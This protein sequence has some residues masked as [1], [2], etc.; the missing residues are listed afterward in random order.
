M[1][2][3]KE[4]EVFRMLHLKSAKRG[5][6][7]LP[8]LCPAVRSVLPF[9]VDRKPMFILLTADII[10]RQRALKTLK[11]HN[12]HFKIPQNILTLT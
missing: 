10:K 3:D 2:L 4:L 12:N 11:T 6:F 8:P 1:V 7:I 9:I 5:P